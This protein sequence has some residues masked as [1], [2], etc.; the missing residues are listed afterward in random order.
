M[1]LGRLKSQRETGPL[2]GT[3]LTFSFLHRRLCARSTTCGWERRGDDMTDVTDAFRE[4]A[5]GYA[6]R[7]RK[8]MTSES[9]RALCEEQ[10]L[11]ISSNRS[12]VLKSAYDC[13]VLVRELKAF[14]ARHRADYLREGRDVEVV[15]DGIESEVRLSV[16]ACQAHIGLLRSTVEEIAAGRRVGAQ[17]IAHLHGVVLILTEY[18]QRVAAAFDRCR[19]V[20]FRKVLRTADHKRRRAPPPP[21]TSKKN[22]A[23]SSTTSSSLSSNGHR[24]EPGGEARQGQELGRGE[25]QGQRQVHLSTDGDLLVDELTDLVEQVRRAEGKVVEMSALSSLFASHVQS[26]AQQIERVYA[27]AVESTKNLEGGN[28]EL[29]KTISRRGDSQMIIAVI[30]FV[31]TFGLLFLDWMSG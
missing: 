30:L 27:A 2:K 4:A 11:P 22:A 21:P 28:V 10:P 14:V 25:E 17:G 31:A 5:A 29:R 20:R 3:P 8:A 12:P 6:L 7:S 24:D 16:K 23:G 1:E 13:L 26:Q 18:L 19:E 15:R 9:A